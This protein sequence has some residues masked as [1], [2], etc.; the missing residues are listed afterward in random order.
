MS[1]FQEKL[2]ELLPAI[3]RERDTEGDLRAF[4]GVPAATLDEI[5]ELIEK[6]PQIW[7]VDGCDPGFLPL[8]AATVGYSFD[9]LRGPDTQRAEIKE[10]IEHS[11]RK[12]SLP[13]VRR[14]LENAGWQGEIEETFRGALRLNRRAVIALSKL[15]GQLYSLGVYRVESRSIVPEM[16]RVLS[17]QHPA[18]TRVIFLQW[19]LS[20]QTV[21]SETSATLR[22][23]VDLH[24]AARIRDVFTLGQ[25]KVN[26]GYKLT[27]KQTTWSY[28]GVTQQCAL[29]QGFTGA[30]VIINRWHARTASNKLGCFVLGADKIKRVE[31]SERRLQLEG[32]VDVGLHMGLLGDKA[33][34]SRLSRLSRMHLNRS[35]LSHASRSYRFGFRQID[36]SGFAAPGI[37]AAA[38]LYTVTQWPQE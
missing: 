33:V 31:L 27:K 20:G 30:G 3:Y 21:G 17:T 13:A 29:T 5:K 2:L 16:R 18:G 1:Y 35:K 23:T 14:A 8:L 34:I 36:I 4:L 37:E 12:G 10:V 15:C 38:N 9:P 11:R 24:S 25:R 26:S 28:W 6:L 22:R 7:D 32:D 19:L